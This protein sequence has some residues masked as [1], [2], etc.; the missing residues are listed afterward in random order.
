MK[1]PTIKELRSLARKKGM[2]LETDIERDG[3][4]KF[5]ELWWDCE[6]CH[7]STFW[8]SKDN[9]IVRV[10][11]AGALRALPDKKVAR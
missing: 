1:T 8:G 3:G 10:A 9:K 4:K 11:V 5:V 2:D 6:L 7:F